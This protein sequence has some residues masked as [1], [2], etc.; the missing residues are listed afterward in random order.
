MCRGCLLITAQPEKGTWQNLF[1]A[2]SPHNFGNR[3]LLIKVFNILGRVKMSKGKPQNMRLNIMGFYRVWSRSEKWRSST[4]RWE[5]RH[6]AD[7][8]LHHASY[9]VMEANYVTVMLGLLEINQYQWV[10]ALLHFGTFDIFYFVQPLWCQN[11][12]VKRQYG[13][14]CSKSVGGG[15]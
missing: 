1:R 12:E 8:I 7:P 9:S 10:L 6:V 13:V 14:D 4:C 11:M 15:C 3:P 2:F 5:W